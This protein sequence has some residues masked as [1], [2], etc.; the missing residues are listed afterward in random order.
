MKVLRYS[1][2]AA[3]AIIAA[4]C[5]DKVTVT[6]PQTV[7]TTTT[8][9][10]T[11]TPVGKVNS[12]SVAPA[13]A[14]LTIGQT[15][16]MT[17]AVN[18]DAGIATT[19]T[20]STSD[21][22]KATVSTVGLVAAVAATPGVAICATSTVNVGV[23]GCGSVVVTA[24]SATVPAT[25]S[26]AG[27]FAGSLTT[28]I[29]P[30]N[31]TGNVF[32][33]VNLSPGTEVVQKVYLL[34]G[35]TKVD[36]QVFSAAQS[37][38]LRY[39][40]DNID[41]ANDVAQPTVILTAAT[42]DFNATTGVPKYLNASG[43]GLSVQLFVVGNATVRSTA[44]YA[45]TLTLANIDAITGAW[46]FPSTAKT[47]TDLLG[48]QWR[49]FGGGIA[50][51]NV[52][53]VLY[54]GKTATSTT[55]K[56]PLTAAV[57]TATGGMSNTWS[58]NASGNNGYCN[59]AG[60]DATGGCTILPTTAD[61]ASF[62]TVTSSGAFAVTFGL[63]DREFRAGTGAGA[64][65][66]IATALAPTVSMIFSDGSSMADA[67]FT[68]SAALAMRLDNKGP[69]PQGAALPAWTGTGTFGSTTTFGALKPAVSFAVRPAAILTLAD[70]GKLIQT[71]VADTG[72]STGA[73]NVN[74]AGMTF[75][76]FKNGGGT[77]TTATDT[78]ATYS[79]EVTAALTGTSELGGICY[80][81]TSYDALG[82]ASP[83]YR[84]A[85]VKAG[86][87]VSKGCRAVNSA[88]NGQL[89]FTADGT[90]PVL[91]WAGIANGDF[92][93]IDTAATAAITA[94]AVN[95]YIN[96]AE[97]NAGSDSVSVCYYQNVSNV[98]T[99][100]PYISTSLTTCN[101][102][103]GAGGTG[104]V[105][106]ASTTAQAGGA[107]KQLNQL[108]S[109]GFTNA[110]ASA[111]ILVTARHLDAAG[112]ISNILS[113]IVVFDAAAPTVG[114]SSVPSIIQGGSPALSAFVNDELSVNSYAYEW[115]QATVVAGTTAFA[116]ANVRGSTNVPVG[117]GTGYAIFRYAY[118][119]T[120]DA[121]GT[122]PPAKFLNVNASVSAADN[123]TY[124]FPYY[125]GN[126]ANY[127]PALASFT[128]GQDLVDWFAQTQAAYAVTA[129]D[130]AG[131]QN[132]RGAVTPATVTDPWTVA[133]FV[134]ATVA[135]TPFAGATNS[136]VS[137][138]L[139]GSYSYQT[140]YAGSSSALAGSRVLSSV[141][142]LKTT[143]FA[144][145]DATTAFFNGTQT[146]TGSVYCTS[147]ANG[148]PMMVGASGVSESRLPAST[149]APVVQLFL[150]IFSTSAT[151]SVFQ[152]YATATLL[153]STT[154]TGAALNGCG[155]TIVE[156]WQVPVTPGVNT[157]PLPN[158]TSGTAQ[159]VVKSPR[160]TAIAVP[161]GI[162]YNK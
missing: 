14:T 9:T 46:T 56:F 29:N 130:Q 156:T 141:V 146:A 117:V 148:S 12:V 114:T 128:S 93:T 147:R 151:H 45:S 129:L 84:E 26:V 61:T 78:V 10:T 159:W 108:T 140:D 7:T 72:V 73:T 155:D 86:A 70:S 51:L 131:R 107:A 53:P 98:M 15:I 40:A 80:R 28:P 6:A 149:L 154:V 74:L 100:T 79:T 31:V 91:T 99:L 57:G 152:Y 11:T 44:T 106:V 25:A 65:N 75:R 17:A 115:T 142:R 138:G 3:V 20:W 104:N 39:A 35:T 111:Q 43:Q 50:T 63:Y 38:A 8:T 60:A 144:K 109:A 41:A 125:S 95:Y 160:G 27:V 134:G 69:A 42:A 18:A 113:R 48:Y 122:A 82:N 54:S 81:I 32:V 92:S 67:A 150:P 110:N 120:G 157:F 19:V 83:N 88:A 126:L 90:A 87:I 96:R 97:T 132:V 105:P 59:A 77:G 47:A 30:A 158:W 102:T 153:N 124:L 85:M 24:A 2:I 162:A 49:G 4:A 68:N 62:K 58:V 161:M 137:L 119:S 37:A 16:S 101:R 116:A 112:N 133:S 145:Y 23:K 36:S 123:L 127:G 103:V 66:T 71:V 135:A 55:V 139:D 136:L 64:T 33:Q 52:L 13:T 118:T 1:V 94:G 5:G 121:I 143:R 22:T 76:V 89:A 34:L 21:A